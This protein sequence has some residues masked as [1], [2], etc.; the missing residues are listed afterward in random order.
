MTSTIRVATALIL[1]VSFS[2]ILPCARS[3]DGAG[4]LITAQSAAGDLNGWK[5]FHDGAGDASVKTADVWTLSADGVLRCK[6][7]PKGYLYTEKDYGSFVLTLEWRWPPGK[8]AGSGGV[9][10]RMTGRHKVWPKSLEAQI[11]AGDAGD[12]WGLDGFRLSGPA[13]RRKTIENTPFGTLTN[14][15]KIKPLEKAPGEWNR[16][17][18]RAEGEKVTLSINGQLV[19]EATGCEAAPGKICLTSEG[20]EIEFRNLQLAPIG[21]KE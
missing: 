12:F 10:L 8:K 11:N 21:G 6:G 19:N 5:S 9:L 1:A 15:K 18:I 2:L 7:M 4:Q 13:E 20:D 16:Y 14:L 17:E 3:D